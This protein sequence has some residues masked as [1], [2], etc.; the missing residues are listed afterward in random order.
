MTGLRF[1]RT[2]TGLI[3]LAFML[4]AADPAVADGLKLKVVA[5][6]PPAELDASIRATLQAKAVQLLDG[7]APAIEFWFRTEVPLTAEPASA[8]KALDALRQ[9][10]L[11]GAVA[12]RSARRD[13]KNNAL[14][15][16]I[17]TMRFA[18]QPQDGDHLGT[19]DFNYF[20]VL[21]PVKL[22]P[23]LEGIAD[24][25]AL[26]KASSQE[27]STEHPVILSL[28]PVDTASGEL[29]ALSAPAPE[30]KAIRLKLPAKAAGSANPT[31]LVFDLVYEGKGHL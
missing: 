2:L 30:H 27:T 25:K 21:V 20:L 22:D 16:G 6:E 24:Y 3:G 28:R 31:E 4:S 5:K 7:D 1:R 14:G 29:P 8:E 9:A 13:Y 12:V 23:K 11:L 10:T 26:V 18:L 17:H 15:T 19:S